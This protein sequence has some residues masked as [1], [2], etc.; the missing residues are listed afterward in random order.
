MNTIGKLSIALQHF[1]ETCLERN[2][3]V[4]FIVT[5][6]GKYAIRFSLIDSV[7]IKDSLDTVIQTIVSMYDNDILK[8]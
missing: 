8:T 5:C 6:S 1:S 4:G 3:P 7:I 2:V